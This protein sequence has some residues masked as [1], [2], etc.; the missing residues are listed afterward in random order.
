MFNETCCEIVNL[1]YTK[2]IGKEK[3]LVSCEMKHWLTEK[4]RQVFIPHTKKK[5]KK[6]SR[7][8]IND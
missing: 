5:R 8:T 7:S 2:Q 6:T 3:S 1:K 4:T